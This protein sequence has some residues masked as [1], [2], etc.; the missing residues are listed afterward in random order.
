MS[1]YKFKERLI[2]K[3]KERNVLIDIR[4]EFYTSKTCT[5]CGNIDHALRNKDIYKCKKCP[6]KIDRDFNGARNILLRNIN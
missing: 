1:H 3:A 6:L 5:C 2:N 4:E